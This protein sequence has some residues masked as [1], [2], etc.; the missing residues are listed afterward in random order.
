MAGIS[1]TLY[2][3]LALCLPAK[4]LSCGA[5]LRKQKDETRHI[6]RPVRRELPTRSAN[7]RRMPSA[8]RL[9]LFLLA[10]HSGRDAEAAHQRR[11]I[12]RHSCAGEYSQHPGIPKR[13]LEGGGPAELRYSLFQRLARPD[14][15]AGDRVRARYAWPLLPVADARHVDRRLRV[16]WLAHD[17]NPVRR[18]CR[19]AAGMDRCASGR[20]RSHRRADALCLDHRPHQ[21]RRTGR[22]RRRE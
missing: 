8:C 14:Q 11:Q 15:G 7:R 12:S 21:D 5:R 13:G 16:P 6:T 1:T 9:S 10:G 22:L 19:D 4:L 3:S 20:R 18:F 17:R 2:R